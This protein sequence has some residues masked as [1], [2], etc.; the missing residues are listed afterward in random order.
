MKEELIDQLYNAQ[1]ERYGKDDKYKLSEEEIVKGGGRGSGSG[2]SEADLSKLDEN[3]RIIQEIVEVVDKSKKS[4]EGLVRD[5]LRVKAIDMYRK[6]LSDKDTRTGSTYVTGAGITDKIAD[7]IIQG[8]EE[9]G[10]KLTEA[11][12]DTIKNEIF[13]EK[14]FT[15][16]TKKGTGKWTEYTFDLEN[17]RNMFEKLSLTVPGLTPTVVGDYSF[18]LD[19]TNSVDSTDPTKGMTNEEKIQYYLDN[20]SK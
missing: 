20:S 13:N 7:E 11:E 18:N 4:P 1:I 5:A 15:I 2:A 10:E 12:K 17:P 3:K 19:T 16:Y 6:A 14:M 8:R 9:E